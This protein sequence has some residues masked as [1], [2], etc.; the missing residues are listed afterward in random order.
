[1]NDVCAVSSGSHSLLASVSD[2]R[3]VRLWDVATGASVRS[4]PV[5]HVPLACC[6][7]AGTLVIGLDAGMMAIAIAD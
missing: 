5:H 4:I 6:Y 7:A 3:T 2:D 1:M